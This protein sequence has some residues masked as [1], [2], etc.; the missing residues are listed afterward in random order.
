MKEVLSKEQVRLLLNP[1]I[2]MT[3][4]TSFVE[5]YEAT[6]SEA[7]A[8]IISKYFGW[9]G[10]AI[11]ETLSKSLED[12]NFHDLGSKVDAL[13]DEEFTNDL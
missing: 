10:L 8:I 9:D 13:L 11:G 4:E 1:V 6:D 5:D 2:T 12:A 7:M 3:K